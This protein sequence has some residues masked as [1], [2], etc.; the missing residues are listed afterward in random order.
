MEDGGGEEYIDKSRI[1]NVKPLRCLAPIFSP[2]PSFPT[3]PHPQAAPPFVCA[4]PAGPFHSGFAPFYPYSGYPNT[5]NMQTSMPYGIN[6]IGTIPAVPISSFRSEA[7]GDAGRSSRNPGLSEHEE[8][9][10]SDEV[11]VIDVEDS[12]KAAPKRKKTQKRTRAGGSQDVNV[13]SSDV[14]IDGVVD[15]IVESFN[16]L[17]FD[18]FRRA[19]GDKEAVEYIRLTYDVL[20]RKIS[21]IEDA[22]ES[23]PGATRR[24]NLRAGTILMNKGIRTNVK[25]RIGVV[26]G[27][28]IGDIF[29]FRM[30]MCLIGLHAPI[31]AGIDYMGLKVSQGEEPVA[32]SIVSSGGYEDNSEDG[33][34][35]VYS[36]QGGNVNNK[37]MEITDQKLERGNLAL[38][39]SLHRGNEVRVIRGV[40]DISNPTGKIYVYDG[41]YKIQD[42]WV[43]KGKSGC[44]V[45]KYKLVRLSGQPEAY[46]V[47]KSVQQWKDGSAARVGLVLQDLTFGAE[48]IPVSLVNDVD[49]EKGLANFTY[50]P[51]LRYLKPVNSNEYSTGCDCHGGCIASNSNCPCIQRNGGYLPYTANGVL[52]S[53]KAL[54][55]ECGSSCMCPPNCKN[56]VCQSGLKVRLEVFKTKDK[57]WGLR[58]WDPIRSGAFICEYAGEVIDISRAEELGGVNDDDYIFDANRSCQSG[59][60]ILGVSNVTPKIPFPLVIRAKHSGNV[61]RFMNHSCSPN[62]FCQPVLRENSKECDLHV[63]FYAYRH[64]P[65]MTELT[66]SYGIVPPDRAH[67]RRKKCLCGSAKCVGYFY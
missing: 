48:S 25:K 55:H 15:K 53:Q 37:G 13:A 58:S 39:K 60:C 52:V 3:F 5:Q 23:T 10:Y 16:L 65:P 51:G 67:Q 50:Y 49:D 33:D 46:T 26:P 62:V 38:E 12:S 19:D 31:M 47:W 7:N 57:G 27:V 28:E 63:A 6:G 9:G 36:G 29:F 32:V 30:E 40:K 21:Q 17:D 44:N 35:L 61:A 24:P 66:Y 41:L 64:I 59:E 56:R 8:D 4:P 42:S 11:H 1:L 34:V 14:D 18:T 43:D 2:M 22:K 54:I 20:R 45:F